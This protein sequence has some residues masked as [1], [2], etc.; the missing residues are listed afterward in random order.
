MYVIQGPVFE[1]INDVCFVQH[2]E[3]ENTKNKF[4][5]YTG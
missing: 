5:T 2:M 1:L 3:R 4:V